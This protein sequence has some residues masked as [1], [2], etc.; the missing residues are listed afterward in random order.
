MP[1][2]TPVSY[3]VQYLV[4]FIVGLIGQILDSLSAGVATILTDLGSVFTGA[5]GNC[6]QMAMLTTGIFGN[7]G[8][9]IYWINEKI[10][11]FLAELFG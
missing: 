6:T 7:D 5:A 8:G 3:Q 2:P 4:S 11:W 9:L 10:L 1:C